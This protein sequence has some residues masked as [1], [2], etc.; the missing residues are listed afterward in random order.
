MGTPPGRLLVVIIPLE[1]GEKLAY[2]NSSIFLYNTGKKMTEGPTM[3][4]TIET[5][6]NSPISIT[7]NEHLLAALA[8]GSVLLSLFGPILPGIV[9]INQ[10]RKSSYVSFQALQAL[11]YQALLLWVGLT[12]VL[13]GLLVIIF[14]AFPFSMGSSPT[15]ES[16]LASPLVEQMR[17]F[18]NIFYAAWGLLSLPGL[19]GAGFALL[20][21]SFHYPFLGRWLEAFLKQG[22]IAGEIVNEKHEE[23]WVAGIC[24]SSAI[25][26]IWGMVLPLAV[27]LTQKERSARLRFQALQAF[28]FQLGALF[29]Y[30]FAFI[31]LFG[32]MVLIL[33]VA[34]VM[35]S[36]TG[37]SSDAVLILFIAVFVLMLF[38]CILLLALPTYH[39]FALI[40]WVRVTKGGEYHYP[41]LGK[42]IE[43]RLG[44]KADNGV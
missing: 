24:H 2:W 29:I 12:L 35:N 26:M 41:L 37:I 25:V 15:M 34:G 19:V 36:S 32:L 42:L 9:W 7:T 31:F 3:S 23:D 27:W 18:Q 44:E 20:G 1:N 21:R 4:E 11:G 6:A 17:L 16:W 10:R 14:S 22:A 43:K 39:L 13:S 33:V 8:H 40:A 30:V 5:S 38:L 28:L